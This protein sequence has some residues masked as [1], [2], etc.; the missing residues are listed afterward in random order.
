MKLFRRKDKK[1]CKVCQVR[2]ATTRVPGQRSN[3]VG[4][5]RSYATRYVYLRDHDLCGQCFRSL[6]D[7]KKAQDLKAHQDIPFALASM[8]YAL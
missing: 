8:G 5:K 1:L 7:W 2:Q 4:G 3:A 6:C